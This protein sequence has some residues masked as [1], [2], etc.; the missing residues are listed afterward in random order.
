MLPSCTPL[1]KADLEAIP[2]KVVDSCLHNSL[3]GDLVL[4]CGKDEISHLFSRLNTRNPTYSHCGVLNKTD[5]GVF[6]F[7]IL[8]SAQHNAG[9]IVYEPFE[10]FVRPEISEKWCIVQYHFDRLQRARFCNQI[11]FYFSK[12][13]LFDSE[14]NLVSDDKMYCSEMIYK[15]ILHS[16]LDSACV[17]STISPT[18]KQYIAID[19]LFE[20]PCCQTICEIAY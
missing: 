17:R 20:H 16:G 3:S 2:H 1:P 9:D 15:A 7:H 11:A 8:S 6:V 18:G 19:N 13:I 12:N 14:F 5:S 4:R 10:R